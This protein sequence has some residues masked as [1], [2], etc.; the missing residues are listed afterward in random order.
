MF[1]ENS[2]FAL[3]RTKDKMDDKEIQIYFSEL[4]RDLSV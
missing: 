3:Y 1:F 2:D 4:K